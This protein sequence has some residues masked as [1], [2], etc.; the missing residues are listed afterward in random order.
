[1]AGFG[2]EF[3]HFIAAILAIL[4]S[5]S[6]AILFY[7]IQRVEQSLKTQ[8]RPLGFAMLAL[9]YVG[10]ILERK[11]IE[12]EFTALLIELVGLIFIFWG[13]RAEPTLKHLRSVQQ[14]KIKLKEK[15][16]K[17]KAENT[18]KFILIGIGAIIFLSIILGLIFGH[19]FIVEEVSFGKYIAAGIV[20]LSSVFVLGTIILQIRRYK[21]DQG[22]SKT[23]LLNLWPL[24]GYIFL[25]LRGLLLI[26]YRFPDTKLVFVQ[27]L[28]TFFGLP[29]Q[30]A[31]AF[32][33]L[34]FL[35]LGI[36]AWNFI[37]PRFFIRTY[38]S[39]LAIA[40]LVSSLGAL[41]FTFLIFSLVKE[42]NLELMNE[43]AQ[44]QYL[45]MED[46]SNTAL[47]LARSIATGRDTAENIKKD[48]FPNMIEDTEDQLF[49]S[50][51][52]IVRIY[53][54]SGQV[55]ASPGDPREKG[56][57]YDDDKILQ[58]ALTEKQSIKSFGQEAHVLSPVIT[59]RG[60]YP[61]MDG[62]NLIGAVEVAYR[63]DTAF[64]DFS[65]D[66][67]DLDVTIYTD[68]LR[69]ATTLYKQDGVSRWVGTKET[70]NEVLDMVLKEG[71]A[72]RTELDRLGQTYYSAFVPIRDCDGEII[73]MVSVG[74]PTYELFEE[75]R[76][77]LITAFLILTIVS[78][79]AALVGYFALKGKD[80]MTDKV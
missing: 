57:V 44:A 76:Q 23:K 35:F 79:F 50:G 22:N 36:W 39:F 74:T 29:W 75:S 38:V 21:S 69:S 24:I 8:W 4:V 54:P 14:S 46:R 40:T 62:D 19:Q 53:D 70:E 55:I 49:T 5:I 1:M 6:S 59:A 66:R 48:S 34:G 26:I 42:D 11:F 28:K 16:Q 67:T 65:K 17:E 51:A 45:V 18:R 56:D 60:I 30:I 31:I 80:P 37:K 52:D 63:L 33:F 2:Y 43:G 32:T 73:G 58:L 25:F 47:V 3:F 15:T 64:V 68:D 61:V 77:H 9:G 13:V 20:G 78:I 27:N 7:L 71:L 10:F 41:V 12:F 72:F